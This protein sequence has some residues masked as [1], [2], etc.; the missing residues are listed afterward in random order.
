MDWE[1]VEVSEKEGVW[2]PV[3]ET[4]M[5]EEKEIE[6]VLEDDLDKEGVLV[7]VLER[8]VEGERETVLLG[9]LD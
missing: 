2:D 4:E 7:S 9:V 3:G 1:I 8:E 6:G 5:E